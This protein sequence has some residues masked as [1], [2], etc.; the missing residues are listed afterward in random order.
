MRI[1]V[2]TH[3]GAANAHYRAHVPMGALARRGHQVVGACVRSPRE[4]PVAAAFAGFDVV[5]VWRLFYPPVWR[6]TRALREQGVGVVWDND[7]DVTSLP[8]NAPEY[9]LYGGFA[10]HR[11]LIDIKAMMA[12]A[13]VV[14]TPSKGLAEHFSSLGA[15]PVIVENYL[16]EVLERRFRATG[17]LRIG[18][19][20]AMEHR[21][22]WDKMD[23]SAVL[24]RLMDEHPDLL[25]ESAGVRLGFKDPRYEHERGVTVESLLYYLAR[26]DIGI[27]PLLDIPFNRARSNVKLK[28]YAAAGAAWVASDVGPYREMGAGEGGIVVGDDGWYP[29]LKTL[30]VDAEQ[31]RQL[32]ASGTS[33]ARTQLIDEHADRWEDVLTEAVARARADVGAPTS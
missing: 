30:V 21:R 23:V 4:V 18:W 32:V 13:H 19:M 26:Y 7:D 3:D 1:A 9:K 14:T 6:L 2:L 22:D 15:Q 20:A 12:T 27:A 10:A 33:W 16:T 24:R 25:V 11:T 29:A 8:R 5:Y 28:E 17:P 31:R